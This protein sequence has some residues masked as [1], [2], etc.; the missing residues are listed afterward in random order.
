MSLKDAEHDKYTN[1]IMKNI[2]KIYDLISTY[3]STLEFMFNRSNFQFL[4][5]LKLNKNHLN[6]G[7]EKYF[8]VQIL[9]YI[10]G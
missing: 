10:K 6:V 2:I 5:V 8:R 1:E 7:F 9:V 4:P 3:L